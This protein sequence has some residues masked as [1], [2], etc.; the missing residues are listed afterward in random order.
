MIAASKA[1][2]QPPPKPLP[3]PL[4]DSC[5]QDENE[6]GD[7]EP[8]DRSIYQNGTGD[9]RGYYQDGAYI[10]YPPGY[11]DQDENEVEEEYGEEDYQDENCGDEEGEQAEKGDAPEL[12]YED[13]S[14]LESS[15]DGPHNSNSDEIREA[16]FTS[17][18]NR[19]VALR[20]VLHT[21]PPRHL[22]ESLPISNPTEVSGFGHSTDAFVKW[23]GRLR[24]TDPLPAQ[25]ASMHKDSVFRLLRVILIGKFL[26]KNHQLWV[27]TS[28]WIWAL[29][30][31]L[32]DRGEL[33]YQEIGWIRELG[34]K[35]VLMMVSLSEIEILK[36][37][38]EVG[39]S[40]AGS[41]VGD[42]FNHD[43]GIDEELSPDDG[44]EYDSIENDIID[45]N[46]QLSEGPNGET[47]KDIESSAEGEEVMAGNTEG[48][49]A[50]HVTDAENPAAD[51]II[52][53][54]ADVEMEIDSD[55]GE[56][57]EVFEEPPRAQEPL[58]DIE[59]AK[60][61]LLSQ[62]RAQDT[63]PNTDALADTDPDAGAEVEDAPLTTLEQE[64]FAALDAEEEEKQQELREQTLRAR[65]NE[66]ATLNMIL[67]VAGE[68]YGQ[69]DLLEF[70]DPFGGLQVE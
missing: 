52:L 20:K 5:D 54:P 25:I 46:T 33:D 17:L 3:K 31:R 18:V 9:F 61:R 67:T 64:A 63:D 42:E 47:A 37:H 70:R 1:G 15:E 23:S 6:D 35:A 19:Y 65:I 39:G 41:Q 16:Y 49:K 55:S 45:P 4:G 28:R 11:F 60:E 43:E 40:S 12:E 29:L 50:N 2:P 48:T 8:L 58:A 38:Y 26:R 10:A 14:S 7:T 21:D 68:F 22:L 44:Y 36:E 51:D 62:L 27:R 24:G 56:E 53:E 66:R 59:M 34:K 13:E 30:A 57:G 69:R 32:P